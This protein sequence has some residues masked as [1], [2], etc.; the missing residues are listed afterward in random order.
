MRTRSCLMAGLA[1]LLLAGCDD[2]S[3]R[4]AGTPEPPAAEASP[5]SDSSTERAQRALGEAGEAARETMES[6]GEAGQAGLEALEENAPAIR[7]GIGEA[8]QRLRNAADALLA[9]PDAPAVDVQGDSAADKDE[10][11]EQLE[12]PAR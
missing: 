12:T 5:P 9:D 10:V 6:L 7:D 1:A 11:P 4:A 3:E 8:G 2:S